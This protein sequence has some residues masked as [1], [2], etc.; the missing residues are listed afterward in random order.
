MALAVL[1][2]PRN[3]TKMY[4]QSRSTE[5]AHEQRGRAGAIVGLG[6]ATSAG[7]DEGIGMMSFLGGKARRG[8]RMKGGRAEWVQIRLQAQ[9]SGMSAQQFIHSFTP[10]C[11]PG[12]VL[13]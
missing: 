13:R 8:S 9:L 10:H 3:A 6:W 5:D 4:R 1:A 12:S 11:S 7:G 2:S